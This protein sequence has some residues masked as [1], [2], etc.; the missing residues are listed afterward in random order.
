MVVNWL[1]IKVLPVNRVYSFLTVFF[2]EDNGKFD[3]FL[4]HNWGEEKSTHTIVAQYNKELQKRGLKTWFDD[5]QMNGNIRDGMSDGV[6]DSSVILVFVTKAYNEKIK[7]KTKTDNLF[8]EFNHAANEK[9]DAM[10]FA[11]LEEEM[12]QT[13]TWCPRLRAEGGAELFVDIC[14]DDISAN[15]TKLAARIFEMIKKSQDKN[16]NK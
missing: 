11:V 13:S 4:S 2:L 1:L 14:S 8:F 12:S 3:V 6:A 15:C 16:T 9:P 7:K 5:E 10:L